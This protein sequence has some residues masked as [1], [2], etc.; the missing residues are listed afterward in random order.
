MYILLYLTFKSFIVYTSI[1][2]VT[3][4]TRT[5]AIILPPTV[6]VRDPGMHHKHW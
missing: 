6:S 2:I 4:D 5:L 1:R 3:T